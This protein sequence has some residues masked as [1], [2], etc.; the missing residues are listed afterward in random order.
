MRRSADFLDS[1]IKSL[2]KKLSRKGAS[3]KTDSSGLNDL[4][5]GFESES[6]SEVEP[7]KPQLKRVKEASLVQPSSLKLSTEDT[8]FVI[9]RVSPA[10]HFAGFD[11]KVSSATDSSLKAAIERVVSDL[12]SS[13]NEFSKDDLVRLILVGIASVH[14]LFVFE[15]FLERL[16]AAYKD[17]KSSKLTETVAYA[18]KL[19]ILNSSFLTD[20][21]KS[22]VTQNR[23]LQAKKLLTMTAKKL[24]KEAPRSVLELDQL[25]AAREGNEPLLD[26]LRSL[27][28]RVRNN[29][30][31]EVAFV[32]NFSKLK[33][34][35]EPLLRPLK[36]A[37][38][39]S[40]I[41]AP[42]FKFS[43]GW[44]TS[45]V[46]AA[47]SEAATHKHDPLLAKYA[48]ILDKLDL[49]HFNERLIIASILDS[50]SHFEAAER[51][52]KTNVFH[53]NLQDV[54]RSIFILLNSEG[55]F[56]EYYVRLSA[57]LIELID[58]L[59]YAFYRFIWGFYNTL[60]AEVERP[61]V[62]RKV[63]EMCV[64]LLKARAFDFKLLKNFD[65]A[66]VKRGQRL[67]NRNLM[68]LMLKGL[69]V[70]VV[71]E[72]LARLFADDK[73][74]LFANEFQEYARRYKRL[75][76]EGDFGAGGERDRA[77]A[78]LDAI[79]HIK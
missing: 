38:S 72:E 42:D 66:S 77:E 62:C 69:S 63:I 7:E 8:D 61:A 65:F 49:T 68:K 41:T 9:K 79:S 5:Q 58:D 33:K 13:D 74:L 20:Y 71:K 52:K 51:I 50:K 26:Q 21:L 24:R 44:L 54:P 3:K 75:Y 48:A 35:A 19:G 11:Q 14:R 76:L 45:R 27:V 36:A 28:K 1:Q 18:Y 40:E 59:K 32:E 67:F 6:E 39:F 37:A 46:A 47:K 64:G 57:K 25:T 17:Q 70:P 78:A 15:G 10:K 53:K 4:F 73:R 23:L 56:N 31:I 30:D 34:A 22:E 55:Q 12:L 29:L 60:S 16:V 2:E 43:A